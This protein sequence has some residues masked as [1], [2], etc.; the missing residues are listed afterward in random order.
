VLGPADPEADA[1]LVA[2]LAARP[3]WQL[4]DAA[5]GAPGVVT[6]VSVG[7]AWRDGRM[8]GA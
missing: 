8:S 1:S 5:I 4:V 7:E 2:A 3:G 6:E